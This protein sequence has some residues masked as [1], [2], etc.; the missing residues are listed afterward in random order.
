[1]ENIKFIDYNENINVKDL[2]NQKSSGAALTMIGFLEEQLKHTGEELF[3]GYDELGD[4][5]FV[6]AYSEDTTE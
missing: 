3:K 1:M 5:L 6:S 2:I 4:I